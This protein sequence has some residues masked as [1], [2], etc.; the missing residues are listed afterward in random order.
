MNGNR[1]SGILIKNFIAGEL[2]AGS[3]DFRGMMKTFFEK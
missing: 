3:V 2:C 1:K